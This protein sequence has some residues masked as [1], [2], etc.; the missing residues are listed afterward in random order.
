MPPSV[1]VTKMW[2]AIEERRALGV[3]TQAQAFLALKAPPIALDN[4]GQALPLSAMEQ[5]YLDRIFAVLANPRGRVT[6]LL[7]SGRLC[8]DEV[9]P[10]ATVFPAVWEAIVEDA[11]R[12]MI[13]SGGPPFPAWVEATLTVLFQKPAAAVY[14]PT[15]EKPMG[16][17][18]KKQIKPPEGTQADRRELAVREQ[19]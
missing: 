7:H 2:A 8:P 10:I 1:D 18:P 19:R 16:S 5:D 11:Q 15:P 3:Q 9:E 4:W 17:P 12:D 14:N 13:D 6:A